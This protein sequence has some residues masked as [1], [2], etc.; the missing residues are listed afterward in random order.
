MPGASKLLLI[1]WDAADWRVITPLVDAGKMP[2]LERLINDGVSGNLATLQPALSPMLW[3]SIATGKRPY[4]HGVHGFSEPDPISGAIRPVTNLSR[5]TK[6]MW[7]ILN[8]EGL[9]PIVIGWWPSHPAEPLTRGVMVSNHYQRATGNSFQEWKMQPGC[10]Y[11]QRL[12]HV[13]SEIR[14]HPTDIE[15]D[16][17]FTVLPA[18]QQMDQGELDKV[19]EDPRLKS[20]MRILADCTTIHSAA[21]ALLQNEPWDL[22]AVYYDAIDHFGHGFMRYHPPRRDW[23]SEEDFHIWKDVIESGYRYHDMMLGVL[24][25]LAGEDATV[26]VMSDHGF[27]P[28]HMRPRAIPI[29]PAGPAHEHRQLG[30]L[31]AKGPGLRQDSLIFGSTVIDICPTVLHHFGLPVG[32]DMDGRILLDLWKTPAEPR[33]IPSW[34]DVPGDDGQHPPD[35]QIAPAESKAAIDQLVALGYIEEPGTDKQQALEQTV[36]ELDYNLACAYIDGGIFTEAILILERLHARW[37][38]E[39]R[40]G[41]NLAEC[42]RALGRIGDLREVTARIIK[43]RLE[44]AKAAAAEITALG[45]EKPE[46]RKAEQERLQSIPDAEKQ[47]FQREREQLLSKAQPNLLALRYLEAFADFAEKKYDAALGKLE[48]LDA[49]YL[50][51]RRALSLRGDIHIR[52]RDWERAST[53]YEQALEIDREV[54]GPHLG[55]ARACLGKR[56]FAGAAAHARTSIGLGYHQPRAHFLLGMALYRSGDWRSAEQSFLTAAQQAPLMAANYRMLSEIACHYKNDPGEAAEFRVMIRQARLRLRGTRRKDIEAARHAAD[57]PRRTSGGKSDQPLPE[58][59]ARLESLRGVPES[60]II[61]VVTGLPRSGT[62]LMMQMLEAAGIPAFTDGKRKADE[63]NPRGYYEHEQVATLLDQQ[64]KSWLYQA[65]GKA[66]KV[67]A[68]LLSALPARVQVNGSPQPLKY[69]V[70]FMERD[71][72]E[73]LRSQQSMLERLGR[74]TGGAG[75]IAKTFRQQ[76]YAARAILGRRGIA[77]MAVDYGALV[78]DPE[79]TAPS[80]A[81]FI[82][83]EDRQPAMCA[84]VHPELQH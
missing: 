22:A 80:I 52:Q 58:I 12:G 15:Q 60:E 13:L 53:A 49:D 34:D 54:A 19:R 6:A 33:F 38:D 32:Q 9:H 67:V 20:L 57:E 30:I 76:M 69:R 78:A 21:T 14:L 2:H 37:P 4:K 55:L 59:L 81:A 11:P 26:V 31:A 70:L 71:M 50:A 48:K 25:H 83:R 62:S 29:E 63:S 82:N 27:H 84:C 66:V 75:G 47:K 18:L 64:D 65:R 61:T 56:D 51:R 16:V 17:L 5:T 10:V 77:A 46:M 36:R 1:G 79:A 7:N 42:Y 44:E 8:Q 23:I 35:K 3:T 72:S 43:R 40:F 45:L 41:I 73:I 74:S 28:D 68:P 24:M 39:H